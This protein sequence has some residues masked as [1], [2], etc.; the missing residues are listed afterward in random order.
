MLVGAIEEPNFL[1]HEIGL[2]PKRGVDFDTLM[3]KVTH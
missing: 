2:L 3:S 1:S